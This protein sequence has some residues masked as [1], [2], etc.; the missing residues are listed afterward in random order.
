[1]ADE[2]MRPT[3]FTAAGEA[4]PKAAVK[5]VDAATLILWRRTQKGFEVLMG[6]RAATL[7]FMPGRLVFPGGRVDPADRSAKVEAP[8]PDFT[9]AC[10]E[11]RAT[12]RA[13][14]ALAVA[15]VREL[16]EETALRIGQG[17]ALPDLSGLDYLCRA[18]TPPMSPV[19][20]NARFLMAPAELATGT[21]QGSG[22]LENLGFFDVE[23]AHRLKLAPITAKV[24]EEFAAV[25]AMDEA[26][27]QTRILVWFQ[28]RDSRRAER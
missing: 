5:P 3:D 28:G 2:P 12:P 18:V 11:R 9:R 21:L 4:K 16:E 13:A 15:A 8:L 23:D 27:R 6:H 20:F 17:A 26:E 24:L 19:R 1:M 14:H 7:R 22:E 10:L 25:M